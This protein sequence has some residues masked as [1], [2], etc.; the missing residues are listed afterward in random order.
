[1]NIGSQL[2]DQYLKAKNIIDAADKELLGEDES[3]LFGNMELF[4][5]RSSQ[6]SC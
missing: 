3:N 2:D 4:Q 5:R 6:K 1:M